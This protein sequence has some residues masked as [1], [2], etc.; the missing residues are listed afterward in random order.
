M[1]LLIVEDEPLI[2]RDLLEILEEFSTEIKI[3]HTYN[4]AVSSFSQHHFDFCFCDVNLNG[5]KSG[6][7]VAIE[8]KERYPNI[9]LIYITS[10]IDSDTIKNI[11]KTQPINLISKPYT[12]D[13]VKASFI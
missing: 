5:E 12:P 8:V 7:D 1:K 3:V 13:Q 11:G 10:Y 2:A 9:Q 6:I 4:Q